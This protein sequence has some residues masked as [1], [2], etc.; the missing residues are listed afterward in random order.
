VLIDLRVAKDVLGE[1]FVVAHSDDAKPTDSEL[2]ADTT[3]TTPTS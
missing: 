1:D 3:V 2:D